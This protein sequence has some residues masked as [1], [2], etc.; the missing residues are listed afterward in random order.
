MLVQRGQ[1]NSTDF[2]IHN[3]F[4]LH[5]SSCYINSESETKY[6]FQCVHCTLSGFTANATAYVESG[7]FHEHLNDERVKAIVHT[8]HCDMLMNNY[9]LETSTLMRH[10]MMLVVE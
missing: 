1:V 9:I 4:K 3:Y 2:D 10:Q 5:G 7:V 6:S 8:L